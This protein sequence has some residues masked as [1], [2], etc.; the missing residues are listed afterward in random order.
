MELLTHIG[1]TEL[2]EVDS[3]LQKR[4]AARAILFNAQNQ[5]PLLF[6]SKYNFHKLPGGGVDAG[7]DIAQALARECLEEVGCEI[8]IIG[9]VGKITEY[10]SKWDLTQTSYCYYGNITLKGEPNFTEKELNEGFEIVWLPLSDA[11]AKVQND[12][13]ENYEGTFVQK[14]DLVFLQKA[15]QV[16][17][18]K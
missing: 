10:R 7:E 8:A 12:K 3:K 13:P 4:E 9:E 5:I 1:D 16:L 17:E 18:S 6:V 11:I 15:Q 14:R 2:P